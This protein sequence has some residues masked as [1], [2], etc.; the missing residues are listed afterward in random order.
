V[1]AP[2]GA[3]Y[4]NPSPRP[5]VPLITKTL[6]APVTRESVQRIDPSTATN[7]PQIVNIRNMEIT[8]QRYGKKRVRV[9]RVLRGADGVH[10]VHEIEAAVLLDGDFSGSYVTGDN[11]Q[12]VPTDTVKNTIQV[13]AQKHLGEVIEEFALALGDHFLAHYS[14]VTRVYVELSARPWTRYLRPDGTPHP[15]AFLGG[16]NATP[17][18]RIEVTRTGAEVASGICDLLVLKTTGSSFVGYPKCGYTTLPETND[19]I[20]STQMEAKW[21]FSHRE[22]EFAKANGAIVAAILDTFAETF[23]P[24]VQNTLY[25]T[26]AAA[27][28]AAPE[29]TEI[30]LAMPNK[31]YLPVSFEPFGQENDKEIYLPT[32]EPH[33]QIEARVG[34]SGAQVIQPQTSFR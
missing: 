31:H 14:Q 3:A 7:P 18:T 26:A 1:D 2:R 8:F 15:H 11:G 21:T 12:V 4:P 6:S 27:L 9:L 28:E 17:F 30:S 20:L 10:T 33:G 23:S 29:I 22:V 16:T 13:L 24:S 34:R 32:D 25:L 19:R 5:E